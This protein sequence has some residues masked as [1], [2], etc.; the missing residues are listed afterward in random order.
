MRESPAIHIVEAIAD[1]KHCAVLV[2]EPNIH[3]VPPPL[4]DR[5]ELVDTEQGLARADVVVLLVDHAPFKAI[6]QAAIDGKLLIDTRGVFAKTA[7]Q[8]ASS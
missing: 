6:G 7:S 8:T 1:F 4:A 2:V 3:A 5:V